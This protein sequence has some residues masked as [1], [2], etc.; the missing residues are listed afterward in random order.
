MWLSGRALRQQRKRL[1]VRVP[2]NTHTDEK[3]ITDC[4]CK[5][6]WIKA[7]AKCINV[8]N[9]EI[10]LLTLKKRNIQSSD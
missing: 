5:S 3:C 1:W 6:L 2:G 8:N 9:L 4:N 7:S 10:V